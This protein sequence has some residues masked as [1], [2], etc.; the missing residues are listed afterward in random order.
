MGHVP[1]SACKLLPESPRV[2]LVPA[3]AQLSTITSVQAY[4]RLT[5]SISGWSYTLPP[6][7][8]YSHTSE[9]IFCSATHSCE[10]S[11]A[12]LQLHYN[13]SGTETVLQVLSSKLAVRPT[14][15]GLGKGLESR[16]EGLE[17]PADSQ[18]CRL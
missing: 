17:L 11:G 4:A 8:Q 16:G 1:V 9:V 5:T 2:D 13:M 6:S 18:Y 3:Y 12:V 7:C 15:W 14:L 10:M